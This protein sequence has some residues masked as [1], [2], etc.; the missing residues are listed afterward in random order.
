[1]RLRSIG[2]DRSI[3]K[4]IELPATLHSVHQLEHCDLAFCLA[5]RPSIVIAALTVAVSFV[6]L[7]AND[8]TGVARARLSPTIG[9]RLSLE[10][11]GAR[12][13]CSSSPFNLIGTNEEVGWTASDARRHAPQ[14]YE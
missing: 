14:F 1:M 12:M 9:L 7:L 3:L 2:A 6:I 10:N 13:R 8:S 5:I 11:L 4:E